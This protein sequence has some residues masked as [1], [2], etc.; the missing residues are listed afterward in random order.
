VAVNGSLGMISYLASNATTL[1]FTGNALTSI[2]NGGSASGTYGW[3][4]NWLLADN[5]F[6]GGLS[7]VLGIPSMRSSFSNAI[8]TLTAQTAPTNTSYVTALASNPTFISSVASQ[9]LSGS[10]NYGVAVKQ[11]QSLNF[12]AIPSLTITPGRKFTNNV[13]ASSG[14][15]VIQNSGNTA[16]ATVSN[17][18]LTLIGSGSSTITATQAGNS[19]RNPVTA[20]QTL[21]VNKGTQTLNFPAIAQQTYAANKKVTLACTSSAGLNANTAY[22]IDNGAVGS[23][24][25]NVLLIS[26]RG[27]ATIT[28]TNAGNAYGLTPKMGHIETEVPLGL[29]G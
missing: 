7:T 17:N 21:I 26:R 10:N 22:S 18:V 5:G 20:S 28:A 15:P 3:I 9:I 12:P 6:I 8:A 2:Q 13:A 27:T 4:A 19:L 1:G 14:L 23:I 25:N 11:A 16:V 24:S 29:V